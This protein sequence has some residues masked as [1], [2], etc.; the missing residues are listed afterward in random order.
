MTD[1][2]IIEML[3]KE[4]ESVGYTCLAM[5]PYTQGIWKERMQACSDSCAETL[6]TARKHTPEEDE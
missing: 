2:E 1:R 5:V 3:M 6:K 4:V